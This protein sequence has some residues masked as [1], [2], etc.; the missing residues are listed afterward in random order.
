M[1]GVA[2]VA[3]W[4][5]QLQLQHVQVDPEQLAEHDVS[6]EQV[7]DATADSLDAGLLQILGRRGDRHRRF[8]RDTPT[9]GS[10]CDNVLPIVDA[11]GPR[12]RCRSREATDERCASTTWPT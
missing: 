10:T 7:M 5:E 6:L 4:G 8:H 9:R 2:N 11:G 3:I 1:P 12:A